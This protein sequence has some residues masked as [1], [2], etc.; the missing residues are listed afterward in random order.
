MKALLVV[1]LQKG[2]H[3]PQNLVKKIE[4][5][6]PKYDTII[7]TQF[8]KKKNSLFQK[9][10]KMKK[11][12]Q[13]KSP[14]SQF[15]IDPPTSAVIIKKTGYGFTHENLNVLKK[16][17]IKK[18]DICGVDTDMCVLAVCFDLWDE[19]I[20]PR[21]LPKLCSSDGKL[22]DKAMDIIRNSFKNPL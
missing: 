14:E 11:E 15:A 2:F 13:A 7:F 10:L 20:I 3:P 8:I 1:D 22:H 17:G 5:V 16:L 18:I 4:R 19:E 9:R 12:Y 6:L 21:V